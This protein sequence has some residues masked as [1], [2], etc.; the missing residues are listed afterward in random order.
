MENKLNQQSIQSYARDYASAFCPRVFTGHS[1]L[2][3]KEI[4]GLDQHPQIN[5]LV[6]AH[7]FDEWQKE[8][9]KLHSHYFDFS[10][11]E[12]QDGLDE[13]MNLLSRHIAVEA[14]HFKPLLEK[15]VADT[16]NI[17]FD[18]YEWL[19]DKIQ[20]LKSDDLRKADLEKIRKYQKLNTLLIDK[21]MDR[22]GSMV[23]SK[24]ESLHNIE[25]LWDELEGELEDT[26]PHVKQLSKVLA[27]N[28]DILYTESGL[29]NTPMPT[30]SFSAPARTPV[31]DSSPTKC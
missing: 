6:I 25:I 14:K 10:A 23:W 5:F 8:R 2:N 24:K 26:L 28:L 4:I 22:M 18:P 12:V 15:A 3:G 30:Y 20:E 11:K 21:M 27:P 16:I 13:F 9:K 17:I 31:A 7:L 29:D 1:K 19:I